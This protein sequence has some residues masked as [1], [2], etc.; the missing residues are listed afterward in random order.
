MFAIYITNTGNS[1]FKIPFKVGV[2]YDR[3]AKVAGVLPVGKRCV[4]PNGV[5]EFVDT[6]RLDLFVSKGLI[7]YSIKQLPV[8]DLST[9]KVEYE[10]PVKV[11]KIKK[12]DKEINLEE[13]KDGRD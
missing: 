9:R 4:I 5:S 13:G 8:V 10:K 2:P 7:R 6:A 3:A 12:S 1:P 11:S